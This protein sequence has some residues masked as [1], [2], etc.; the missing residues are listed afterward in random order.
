MHIDD[1]QFLSVGAVFDILTEAG[2]DHEEY[3]QLPTQDDFRNF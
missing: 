2:N 1:M 3:A